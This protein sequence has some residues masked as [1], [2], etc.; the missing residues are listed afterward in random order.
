M[1]PIANEKLYSQNNEDVTI[2]NYF[3]VNNIHE[4][5][6]LEIGAYHPKVFSNTRA[7]VENGWH[8]V[9][10]EPSPLCFKSFEEEYSLDHPRI[11]LLPVAITDKMGKITFWESGGDAVSS[12]STAHKDKWERGSKIRFNK[13]EVESIT[14]AHLLDN[15][16]D[17]VDF[18][19][20]DVEGTNIDLFRLI[21]DTF[22]QRLKMLCIEHD[23][24]DGEI[25]SKLASF[26][27]TEILRNGE[28]LILVK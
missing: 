11:K 19:N 14:M 25:K 9:Y 12:T 18:L 22:W 6:F 4:G 7:L 8:G 16:G 28:N 26:G 27:F 13:I 23:G 3:S 21:P 1:I 10:V 5:K 15:Y 2:R 17:D 24:K 20:L